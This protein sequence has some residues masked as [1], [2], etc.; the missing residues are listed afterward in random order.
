[1]GY[2]QNMAEQT[3]TI[4][5]PADFSFRETLHA[6]GWRHLAPF[7]WDEEAETL[8]RP[9]QMQDGHV[10]LLTL[11]A[12]GMGAVQIDAAP[13]GDPPTLERLARRML[14]MDMLLEQFHAFC[15]Q[16]PELA[17]IPSAGQGRMLVSPTFWEDYVKVVLTTNTTWAQTKSM[18][19]RVVS[20]FGT[21]LP[22]RPTLCAFP[23]P[24]QIASVPLAAFAEQARLGYRAASIHTVATQ[25]AQG[26][27]DLETWRDPA[28]PIADLWRRMLALPGVGPYAGACLLLYGGRAER[29]NA[30]SVARALLARELGRAVSDKDVHAFFAPYGQWQGLVYNFYPWTA[31]VD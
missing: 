24:A 12:G 31:K 1:M 19:A 6:H 14:Q 13:P 15:A 7:H 17:A 20:L 27:L 29:V 22:A 10:H 21:P 16:R 26:L 9:Q 4:A 30:D 2:H 23:T 28:L 3:L 18:T 11:R 25:I 5:A 8:S